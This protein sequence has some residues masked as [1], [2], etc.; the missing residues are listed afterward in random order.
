[1]W[2]SSF[3]FCIPPPAPLPP[4]PP[5]PFLH[6]QS[7]THNFV[8]HNL[9]H[10]THS[11]T[12]NVVTHT[13]TL[14]QNCRYKFGLWNAYDVQKHQQEKDKMNIHIYIY[15][16]IITVDV[17]HKPTSNKIY[18]PPSCDLCA[19]GRDY[20]YIFEAAS[21]GNRPR[22]PSHSCSQLHCVL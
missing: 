22:F 12:H 5:P 9:S 20:I 2:G 18:G 19:Q 1:M 16:R 10:T 21:T 17:D 8:T 15:K 7:F 3:C 6:T 14:A 4:P 13:H 11:F